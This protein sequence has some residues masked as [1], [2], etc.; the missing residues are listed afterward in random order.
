MRPVTGSPCPF[1]L[2]SRGVR[3][4]VSARYEGLPVCA[5][6]ECHPAHAVQL[7][8]C[9]RIAI[10]PLSSRGDRN[11]MPQTIRSFLGVVCTSKATLG[12]RCADLPCGT[13][14]CHGAGRESAQWLQM[15]SNSR[16]A[17]THPTHR[18]EARCHHCLQR[19]REHEC[20]G[21]ACSL[22]A[23]AAVRRRLA[24]GAYAKGSAACMRARRGD[25]S[26][27]RASFAWRHA[28]C[29]ALASDSEVDAGK[30]DVLDVAVVMRHSDR[31]RCVG[32]ERR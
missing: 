5:A 7:E 17:P 27:R 10:Q 24:A 14:R 4:S 31:V 12:H 22:P 11:P 23:E 8:L 30:G 1:A 29:A 16:C 28:V 15:H 19:R 13:G 18:Q 9:G 6:H 26:R 32:G 3:T 25:S 21:V 20:C 2:A